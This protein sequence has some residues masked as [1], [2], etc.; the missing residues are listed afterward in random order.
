MIGTRAQ[1]EKYFSENDIMSVHLR[2]GSYPLIKRGR[3]GNWELCELV[4]E[5]IISIEEI[6]AIEEDILNLCQEFP[7]RGSIEINKG[8]TQVIQLDGMR[9]VI[10]KP[11]FADVT[12]ITAVRQIVVRKLSDY[13]LNRPLRERL[14]KAEGIVIAGRPGEGKTTFSQALANYFA[15][16]AQKIVKTMENPRDMQVV[17]QITRY[18][19]LNGSMSNSANIL[20][21]VRPDYVIYD[22][23]RKTTDFKVYSDLRLAG[24]GMVGIVHASS[25]IDAVQRFLTRTE[26]GLLPQIVDTILFIE[27]GEVI[28]ALSIEMTVGVPSGM[29]EADLARPVVVVKD[30]ETGIPQYEIYTFGEQTV[31]IPLRKEKIRKKRRQRDYEPFEDVPSTEYEFESMRS[32]MLFNV[33]DI[34]IGKKNFILVL[35]KKAKNSVVSLIAEDG[36]VIANFLETNKKG[37]TRIRKGQANRLQKYLKRGEQ[38]FWRFESY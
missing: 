16:E 8:N 31:M 7:T 6:Q 24:V 37:E 23:L 32:T 34:R 35:G 15:E 17:S 14:I 26:L 36:A 33:L 21:L 5:D 9:I 19:P 27:A 3:P 10:A 13:E 38:L 1:I 29:R 30:F 22:E 4:H 2:M 11:P 12:E 25:P 20:L 28:R 18:G